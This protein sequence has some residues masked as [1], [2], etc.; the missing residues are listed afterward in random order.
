M[1]HVQKRGARWQARYRG[2][3]GRERSRR[4]DRKVDAERWLDLNGADIARGRWVDPRLGQTMLR[5][6]SEKWA[7]TTAA[8]RPSTRERDARYLRTHIL[9][10][11]GDRSLSSVTHLEVRGWVAELS[12]RK[13]PATVRLASQ[14][15]AKIMGA[16]VDAG[17]LANNPCDRVPLPRIEREEMRFLTP[18][19][20]ERFAR[21]VAP[22]YRAL[23]LVGA[24][25]GLRIGEMAALRRGRV[26][27]LRGRVD[28]AETCVEVSGHL[29]F[30]QPKTRAGRRS[31][32]LPRS[33]ASVL[34][35]HLAHFTEANPNA[36]VFTAPEGGP[37]RPASWRRRYWHPAVIEAGLN[38]LRPHDLRH[39][40]VALWI[41]S[42]ANPLEVSRRAGHTST[43]FTQD[44]YG[45][46]FPE[47]DAALAERLESLLSAPVRERGTEGV[48]LA[49]PS[50]QG[51]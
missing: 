40:A 30:N 33:V 6:W 19:E 18:E 28:I 35:D 9:P 45:H 23:V 14:M 34:G 46:L 22:R 12:T 21:A 5:E 49:L 31:V 10:A 25:G 26:D 4:F 3:D 50:S 15:L 36:L 44:R 2:P 42:G 13:A 20:V 7:A 27:I 32:S 11:F 8:N 29:I 39:T 17:V 1:S 43:S 38:P 16:A 24:Y 37:L 48:K 51:S 41:A 47:A